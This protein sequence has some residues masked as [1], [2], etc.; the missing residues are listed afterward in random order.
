MT[1]KP[2][3]K[4]PELWLCEACSWVLLPG[5]RV[6]S[7]CAYPVSHLRRDGLVLTDKE[8]HGD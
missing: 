5:A 6:C 3:E 7:R 1:I 8:N 4:Q 2:E